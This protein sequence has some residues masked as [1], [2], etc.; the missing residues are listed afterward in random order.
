MI[1]YRNAALAGIVAMGLT[2]VGG[3][4]SIANASQAAS[5]NSEASGNSDCDSD[6]DIDEDAIAAGNE[7]YNPSFHGTDSQLWQ[8]HVYQEDIYAKLT[9]GRKH[10]AAYIEDLKTG[11]QCWSE[12][13]EG[14]GDEISTG[15]LDNR[16]TSV[17][18]VIVDPVY[19]KKVAKKWYRED[20]G[21]HRQL[22]RPEPGKEKIDGRMAKG[23]KLN[24]D[25]N[26]ATGN[27]RG[28]IVDE[29]KYGKTTR[30][31]LIRSIDGS[32]TTYAHV[33]TKNDEVKVSLQSDKY[34]PGNWVKAKFQPGPDGGLKADAGPAYNK[35]DALR[36]CVKG[37]S[38]KVKCSS[39]QKG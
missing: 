15:Y 28:T 33:K 6:W 22:N 13:S 21:G 24:Y 27:G 37:P 19:G 4:A 39:W 1:K 32:N 3:T 9:A 17:R 10:V 34:G 23:S 20:S 5:P 30:A 14:K 31:L 11:Q 25:P 7:N 26:E 2:A 16:N 35:H 8:W 12:E 36:V 29:V 18:L 38:E